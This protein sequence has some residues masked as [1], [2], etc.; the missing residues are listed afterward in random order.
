MNWDKSSKKVILFAGRRL[1]ILAWVLL[2]LALWIAFAPG[3][4]AAET[5]VANL[6]YFL[7]FSGDQ[8]DVFNSGESYGFTQWQRIKGSFDDNSA[9]NAAGGGAANGQDDSFAKYIQT[10]SDGKMAIVNYFPQ[11]A[12]D[13]LSI[14]TYTLHKAKSGNGDSIDVVAEVVAAVN[15]GALPLPAGLNLNRLDQRYVDNLILV[16]QGDGGG[17]IEEEPVLYP[18]RAVYY[19]VNTLQGYTCGVFNYNMINS[20]V[21]LDSTQRQGVLSH[22]FL[23]SMGLPDLYRYSG[24]GSPV[25]I[26]DHMSSVGRW[27]AYP[28]AYTRS[29]M[30]W[31]T[32]DEITE[33]GTYTLKLASLASGTRGYI[34]RTPLSET[35]FFVA[36]Y[37][38]KLSTGSLNYGFD[39]KLTDS[40]LLLY[41]VNTGLDEWTNARGE[42]YVYVF[43]PGET[44]VRDAGGNVN[45]AAITPWETSEYS[46]TAQGYVTVPAQTGYGSADMSAL[47]DE[48]T[49][50]YSSGQNSGL[51]FSEISADPA[52]DSLSFT[53]T[54][55]DY[56]KMKLWRKLG[57]N[58][59]VDCW[60]VASALSPEGVVYAASSD[61]STSQ[62]AVWEY[63]QGSWQALS[64][65]GKGY[66]TRL[67]VW[68]GELYALYV[69]N[70]YSNMYLKCYNGSSWL[71]VASW[72]ASGYGSQMLSLADGGENLYVCLPASATKLQVYGVEKA[73]GQYTVTKQA[74]QTAANSIIS[75]AM[76]YYNSQ[77]Y[78]AYSEFAWPMGNTQLFV[79]EG[80]SFAPVSSVNGVAGQSNVHQMAAG[81]GKLYLL[82]G[83]N[84]AK[85]TLYSF[86]GIDWQKEQPLD[87]TSYVELNLAADSSGPYLGYV[88]AD[89]SKRARVYY[90]EGTEWKQLHK[91]VN[92][93]VSLLQLLS[94]G[95]SVYAAM[96]MSSNSGD[97]LMVYQGDA[98][99]G[100]RQDVFSVSHGSTAGRALVVLPASLELQG[101]VLVAWYRQGRLLSLGSQQVRLAASST[102]HRLE[103]AAIGP[104][105]DADQLKC[106]V[107]DQ[108]YQPLLEPAEWQE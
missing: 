106:F 40:G 99:A 7:R 41:R 103:I 31:L 101:R 1:W 12:A 4:L 3:A 34:I 26:W 65:P 30:G 54:I 37:R 8:T 107:L 67:L 73:A 10:I 24:N 14:N 97:T 96:T 28:L 55:P 60:G 22:E 81:G 45:K 5:E 46:P 63:R 17:S 42:D 52:G 19:P 68:N 25:G 86:D 38:R 53:L 44:G 35:E 9:I 43:R 100:A 6:V 49:I 36:E 13:G 15:S 48:E 104:V 57:G 51:V 20:G 98:P 85:P 18:H 59:T 72:P 23:H 61:N 94:D 66:D 50:F 90:R 62:I 76:G 47:F 89:D 33:S 75:P 11:E 77:L 58:L 56:D 79:L 83:A 84:N 105:T 82:T 29:Q 87:V 88:T 95:T 21:L 71:Q 91:D 39:T 2:L 102:A 92:A 16:I 108:T 64:S 32:L 80:G 27:Q 70:K 74:E 93:P 78:V 69:D